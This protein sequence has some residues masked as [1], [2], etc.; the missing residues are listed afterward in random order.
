MKLSVIINTKNASSTLEKCLQSVSFADEIIIVDM[1]STDDTIKIARKY[2]Q[3]IYQHEDIGYADPARNFALSK[4]SGRWMLVVDADE[5]IPP[6]LKEAILKIIFDESHDID[7][8]WLPRKNMIF[9]KW[10]EKAGWWPDHQ[11]RLFKKGMVSWQVGVH[12]HPDIKGNADRF[13]DQENMAILH[14]NYQTVEQFL[15]RLN[16][17]TGLQAKERLAVSESTPHHSTQSFFTSFSKEFISRL[18]LKE[19]IDEG[20]HGLSLSLLQGLYEFCIDIK[21]WEHLGFKPT[22]NDQEKTFQSLRAFQNDLNFWIA[23]W[24]VKNSSGFNK[25]FWKVRRKYKF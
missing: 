10:I 15:T 12:R 19:G 23:D 4:A 7:V 21:K 25:L 16:R 14:H 11:V 3:D 6:K 17:Y 9:G 8:Y 22:K 2:T 18:F 1:M 24:K 20:M 5:E 13:P